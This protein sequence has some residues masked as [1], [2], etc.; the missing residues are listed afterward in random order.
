MDIER[1]NK[2]FTVCTINDLSKVN[3]NSEFV[4]VGK[5]DSE[6]S[7]VC[8]TSDVP[9]GAK[10]CEDGWRAFRICGE[11]DFSLVGVIA[12]ISTVLSEANIP[13]FVVSTFNTDYIFIKRE[14]EMTALSRLSQHGYKILTGDTYGD[15]FM[16]RSV[17]DLMSEYDEWKS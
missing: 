4:F 16:N 9:S 8:Q 3:Y 13:V 7:L 12:K 17:S 10:K 14:N 11:L 1:I 15:Y 5:T 2:D 6:L